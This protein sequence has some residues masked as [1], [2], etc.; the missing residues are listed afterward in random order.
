VIDP[1][2]HVLE[3]TWDQPGRDYR[4]VVVRPT[5]RPVLELGDLLGPG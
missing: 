3:V 5:G 2:D 4:G 1:S